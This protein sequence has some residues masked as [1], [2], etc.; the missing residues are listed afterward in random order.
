M[1]FCLIK[2]AIVRLLSFPFAAQRGHT[3]SLRS[4]NVKKSESIL[5]NAGKTPWLQPNHEQIS[6][7]LAFS[8][9]YTWLVI[10]V[11]VW[12]CGMCISSLLVMDSWVSW[13]D[14]YWW[15]LCSNSSSGSFSPSPSPT[16]PS[17]CLLCLSCYLLVF[18]FVFHCR[19]FVL[20]SIY[21]GVEPLTPNIPKTIEFAI[22]CESDYFK[23]RTSVENL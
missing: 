10:H 4:G 12:L 23:F 8:G 1:A 21:S 18:N 9:H 17:V 22:I 20:Y 3:V 19:L 14:E 16:P 13:D 15:V 5:K 11:G 7:S 2:K 6:H